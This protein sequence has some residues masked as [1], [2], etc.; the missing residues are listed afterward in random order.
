MLSLPSVDVFRKRVES[1][2]RKD[3]RMCLMADYIYCGRISEVVAKAYK[4]DNTVARGP[5]GKDVRLDVYKVGPLKE[6]AVVFTVRT[7]KRLGLERKVAIPVVYEPWAMPLYNYYLQFGSNPV[8]SFTQQ[9]VRYWVRKMEVFKGLTYPVET[10]PIFKNSI[11]VNRVPRHNRNFTLHAI[12]HLRA[13]ELV[14][15]YG[16]NGP[17]LAIYGGWTFK[18]I[19]FPSATDRYLSLGWQTYFLKLLKRLVV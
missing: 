8:F 7:A 2:P 6:D 15:F 13:S 12:R 9:F 5:T 10:Y 19:G 3:I 14:D 4:V 18:S 17:E 16:F 11:L 1:V